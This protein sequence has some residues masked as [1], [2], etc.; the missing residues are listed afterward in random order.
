MFIVFYTVKTVYIYLCSYDCSTTCHLFATLIAP[1]N[2]CMYVYECVCVC[3]YVCMYVFLHVGSVNLHGGCR[4][5]PPFEIVK[6]CTS[7]SN[8]YG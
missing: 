2:V 6:P 5:L 7:T 3:M 4:V 1:W 8:K